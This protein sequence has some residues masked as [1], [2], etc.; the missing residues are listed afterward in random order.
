[1]GSAP[2][3]IVLADKLLEQLFEETKRV[4][5]EKEYAVHAIAGA[6]LQRG[7]LIGPE[8]DEIFD[9]ADLSN[10]EAA[11][12]FVRKPVTLPRMSDLAKE[13]GGLTQVTV[14]PAEG[15]APAPGPGP[16]P[17]PGPTPGPTPIPQPGQLGERLV[18]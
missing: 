9:A 8:L 7:E 10:P 14:V 1:M 11:K 17:G 4:I 5:R 15:V 6:L 16:M 18:D 3:A 13:N 12:P 2:Q